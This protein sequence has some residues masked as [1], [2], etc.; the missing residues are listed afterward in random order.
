MRRLIAF[1]III[2]FT[3]TICPVLTNSNWIQ[4]P[5]TKSW[6]WIGE[7]GFEYCLSGPWTKNLN[8]NWSKRIGRGTWEMEF[9]AT[10]RG[11][12]YGDPYDPRVQK[13]DYHIEMGRLPIPNGYHMIS[14]SIIIGPCGVEVYYAIKKSY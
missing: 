9:P 12:W 5:T 8:G 6:I 14:G 7:P 4:N 1:L 3:M 10:G 13:A 2:L 11:Y